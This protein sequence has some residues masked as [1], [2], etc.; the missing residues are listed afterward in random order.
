VLVNGITLSTIAEAPVYA[1]SPAEAKRLEVAS[2]A[3]SS[4][5][6]VNN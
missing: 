4:P 6:M 2:L 5:T 3:L 1:P